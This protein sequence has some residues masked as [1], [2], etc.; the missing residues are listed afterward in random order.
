MV[1]PNIFCLL[2]VFLDYLV[3]LT[4]FGKQWWAKNITQIFH[5]KMVC[6]IHCL[7]PQ[8]VWKKILKPQIDWRID[9]TLNSFRLALSDLHNLSLSNWHVLIQMFLGHLPLT[10]RKRINVLSQRIEM[11]SICPE[12]NH[13][14]IEAISSQYC[15]AVEIN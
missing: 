8:V 10:N 1:I 15:T 9:L 6:T 11:D 14:R 3:F 12:L 2:L 4:T 13:K 5:D 7:I